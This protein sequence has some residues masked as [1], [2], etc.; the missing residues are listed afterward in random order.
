MTEEGHSLSA[1]N[2]HAGPS[3]APLS[4][5]THANQPQLSHSPGV[6]DR[7]QLAHFTYTQNQE[8]NAQRSTIGSAA[9]EPQ[10]PASKRARTAGFIAPGA[11]ASTRGAIQGTWQNPHGH[12][13]GSSTSSL[14]T[15]L[16]QQ[17]YGNHHSAH[18][19]FPLP[20]AATQT[21]EA[22]QPIHGSLGLQHGEAHSHSADLSSLYKDLF[23]HSMDSD[24][25]SSSEFHKSVEPTRSHELFA[26]IQSKTHSQIPHAQVSHP[27]APR[28]AMNQA[29]VSKTGPGGLRKST[30][31][32]EPVSGDLPMSAAHNGG[33]H[34]ADDAEDL[35]SAV[36]QFHP[37]V[38]P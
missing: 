29:Q 38:I 8:S 17:A 28:A 7:L 26:P 24:R 34:R 35:F 27:Q 6:S 16:P 23:G 21:I 30:A 22:H 31:S 14:A 20:N 37:S 32:A 10:Q 3:S 4:Q 36:R 33:Q 5:S 1:D 25:S 18:V 9:H 19:T 12:S 11:H 15:S 13:A 2:S